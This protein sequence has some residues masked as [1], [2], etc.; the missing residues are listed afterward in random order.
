M[1]CAYIIVGSFCQL[2]DIRVSFFADYTEELSKI[3]TFV[4]A[5][6]DSAHHFAVSG[7]ADDDTLAACCAKSINGCGNLLGYMTLVYILYIDTKCS[8]SFVDDSLTLRTK[9]VCG[10]PDGHTDGDVF[11]SDLCRYRNCGNHE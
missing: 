10:A 2:I 4:V 5:G 3:Y 7:V 6:V 11:V 8:C 1:N 9:N